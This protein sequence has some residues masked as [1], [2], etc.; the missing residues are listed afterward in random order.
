MAGVTK[1][2]DHFHFNAAVAQIHEFVNVLA[3]FKDMG[4]ADGAGWALP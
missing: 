1:A 4:G 2:I 3:A